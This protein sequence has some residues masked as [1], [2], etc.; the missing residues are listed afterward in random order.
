LTKDQ[1]DQSLA[2]T[3]A[4][5]ATV[6]SDKAAIESA[7]A[8]LAAQKAAVDNAKI[9]LSYTVIHSPIDGRTGNLAV[10]SGN[11]V[12]ANSTELMTIAQVQPVFVTFTVPAVHLP[13]I[14]KEMNAQK[15]SVV[16]TPQDADAQPA[17]GAL[18]FIDNSVD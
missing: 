18:S 9:A 17:T 6:K 12:T 2:A 10:K 1:A 15:L 4:T 3:D 14:K 7:R 13:T 8:Q 16:A 11:L 5:A